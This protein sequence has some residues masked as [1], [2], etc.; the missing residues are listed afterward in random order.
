MRPVLNSSIKRSAVD[1]KPCLFLV[2]TPIGNLEDL[3]PRA[4]RV[5][6]ECALIVAEDTRHTQKLLN[7]IGIA[8]KLE[9]F[10]RHSPIEKVNKIL[11][12]IKKG[13]SVAYVSD[14]GT[15]GLADPGAELAAR[16]HELHLRVVPVPGASALTT[17]LSASGF[18]ASSFTFH[19]FFPRETK[20]RKA[21]LQR[22][23]GIGGLQVFFETPHRVR[24]S[25]ELIAG[26]FPHAPLCVG[27]ELTKKF[28]TIT[29]GDAEK[30]LEIIE[31][32][33]PRGEYVCALMLPELSQEEAATRMDKDELL[34]LFQKLLDLGADQKLLTQ[35]G[36]SHGFAK[37]EAYE[38]S[39]EARGK[40]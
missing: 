18:E 3:S 2:A 24:E 8:A 23:R 38:I 32:E 5:L 1:D 22:M 15:P 10:H 30:V 11:E 37:N 28:E 33:E 36:I 31:K 35:V 12:P 14:A 25:L 4:A 39:L 29:R 40:R 9:S 34:R 27:R 7:A 17:L 13:E 20:E 21:L 6:K 26:I 19:G 16:A